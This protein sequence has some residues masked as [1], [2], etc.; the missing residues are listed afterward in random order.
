MA[1]K[2][3]FTFKIELTQIDLNQIFPIISSEFEIKPKLMMKK[4]PKIAKS[5]YDAG[6]RIVSKLS[7]I[8]I[9]NFN[10]TS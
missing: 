1:E 6:N 2:I 4:M 9:Q 5:G 7:K 8:L 10:N 3:V